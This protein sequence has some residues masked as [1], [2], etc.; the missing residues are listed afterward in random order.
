MKQ[1]PIISTRKSIKKI[2]IECAS[3]L[4]ARD[5]KGFSNQGMNA[6]LV[7]GDNMDESLK[8]TPVDEQ[9]KCFRKDGTVG[10]ITTDGSSPKHNNRIME[11][12]LRIRKLTPKEC[13]RL[14]AWGF[15]REDGTWDDSAF[16][17]AKAA[18]VSDSQL[19]KQAGNGC[20]ANV[21]ETIGLALLVAEKEQK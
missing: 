16:E 6:C 5:Y 8:F 7:G 12:S 11:N 4:L 17:K 10:T 19:Y 21:V 20:S 15:K 18:G 3:T 2:P 13:W 1:I 9:N 14:Q